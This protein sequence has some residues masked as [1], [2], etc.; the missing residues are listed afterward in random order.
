M[1]SGH[2]EARM[3]GRQSYV[4][5]LIHLPAVVSPETHLGAV[6]EV[7]LTLAQ[8]WQAA[9]HSA[10]SRDFTP[11]ASHGRSFQLDW[12]KTW[13]RHGGTREYIQMKKEKAGK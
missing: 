1:I 5:P 12:L 2:M 6:R 7:V 4:L 11:Q 3:W 13:A 10:H 8:S 9:H